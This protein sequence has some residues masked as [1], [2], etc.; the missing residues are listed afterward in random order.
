MNVVIENEHLRAGIKARG[1]ELF[2]VFNKNTELEYMWSGDP[3]YWGKTSPVLFPIVGTLKDNLYVLD[4]HTYHL[5]RHGFAREMPF[6]AT[7]VRKDSVTFVL[8]SNE[9]LK[10]KYPFDFKLSLEY[11]LADDFLSVN[12]HVQN[13][14]NTSMYFSIGGHPAFKSPL[15]EGTAYEDHL[16]QFGNTENTGRWP[17][18]SGGLIES[19][20]VPFLE[21]SDTIRLTKNLFREDALVLKQLRSN[22]V[23]LK[24][25]AHPHGLDFHFGGFP[26]LGIW[27]ARNADFVCIEPWCGIADSVTHN[28]QLVSKEGIER[29]GTGEQWSREWKVRFY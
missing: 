24:S 14:G 10:T 18:T 16:L 22:V 25:T 28:Q 21:N 4:D 8:E 20:P 2:T 19:N 27:A 15:V 5:D 7:L 11:T 29:L 9:S 3:R 17:I 13:K 23:S 6:E 26:F 1:A 12:Y